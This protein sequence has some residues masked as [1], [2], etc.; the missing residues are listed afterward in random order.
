M[1]I[2]WWQN[3]GLREKIMIG[4]GLIIVILTA[5]FLMLE[6]VSHERQRM[7]AEIP[8]LRDDVAWMKAHI[9][10]VQ[11]LHNASL[12]MTGKDV[13]TLTPAIV[14]NAL[15]RSGLLNKVSDMRPE[16]GQGVNITFDEVSFESLMEF[17][18]NLKIQ[19]GAKVNLAKINRL[20]DKIGLVRASMTLVPSLTR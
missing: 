15:R 12:S 3:L 18:L 16:V 7:A 9:N 14:E 6:P 20:Q 4:A 1:I 10:Q 2:S 13:T 17:L 8:R 5:V 11:V 19:N